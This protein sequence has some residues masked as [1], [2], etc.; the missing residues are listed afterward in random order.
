MEQV[1]SK[2]QKK[3]HSAI[4]N[5]IHSRLTYPIAPL[6]KLFGIPICDVVAYSERRR[7]GWRGCVEDMD[8][9]VGGFDAKIVAC[10]A[11][12]IEEHRSNAGSPGTEIVHGE[13]G[14]EML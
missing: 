10:V 2:L 11:L 6:P 8:A 7:S 3:I 5:P 9:A 12:L 4:L 13:G 1:F 14:N